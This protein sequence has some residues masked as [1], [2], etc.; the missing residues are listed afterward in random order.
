MYLH[1]YTYICIYM[2][3]IHIYSYE[4]TSEKFLPEEEGK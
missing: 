4:L 3:Y 2:Y 1:I